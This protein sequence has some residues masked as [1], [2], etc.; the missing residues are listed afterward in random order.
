MTLK[1]YIEEQFPIDRLI[2]QYASDPIARIMN[3]DGLPFDKICVYEGKLQ[4]VVEI[5]EDEYVSVLDLISLEEKDLKGCAPEFIA[6]YHAYMDNIELE[7][8]DVLEIL[9]I[10]RNYRKRKEQIKERIS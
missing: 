5:S 4:K 9:N 2:S 8:V 1:D 6:V 10:S 7:D 3:A